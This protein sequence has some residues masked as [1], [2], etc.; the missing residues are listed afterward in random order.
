MTPEI[1]SEVQ[2]PLEWVL[3]ISTALSSILGFFLG[4]RGKRIEA[5]VRTGLEQNL[6]ELLRDYERQKRRATEY[7]DKIEEVLTER[8]SWRK[9]YNEQASGHDNAQALMMNTIHNL[10][11]SYQAATGK[12]PRLD[13]LIEAVRQDFVGNHG[14]GAREER[15]AGGEEPPAEEDKESSSATEE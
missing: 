2:T 13:P 12:T 1:L 14:E 8:D 7:F 3:L 11:K 6:P 10:A 15:N 4:R 9:L 5:S